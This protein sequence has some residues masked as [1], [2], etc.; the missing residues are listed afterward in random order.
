MLTKGTLI[1]N[2]YLKSYK[3][4]FDFK[5]QDFYGNRVTTF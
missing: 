1:V 2:T 5:L 3:Q 4:L